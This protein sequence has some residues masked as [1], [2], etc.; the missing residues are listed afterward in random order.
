MQRRLPAEYFAAY[1][2]IASYAV[3]N[4]LAVRFVVDF[5]RRPSGCEFHFPCELAVSYPTGAVVAAALYFHFFSRVAVFADECKIALIMNLFCLFVE[6]IRTRC[7]DA[8]ALFADRKI[9]QL[10]K[11]FF[12][13]CCLSYYLAA[14][15]CMRE[16]S[17]YLV[18]KRAFLVLFV[19]TEQ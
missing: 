19:G 14:A 5:E 9:W 1:L 4:V 16:S 12:R 13:A 3:E 10:R 2:I 15:F 6:T 7:V 17:N 18:I 11:E 8:P